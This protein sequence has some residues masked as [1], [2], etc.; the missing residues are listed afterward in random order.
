MKSKN[1]PTCGFPLTAIVRLCPEAHPVAEIIPF[2]A[3]TQRPIAVPGEGAPAVVPIVQFD[4][5]FAA[6][7]GDE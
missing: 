5:P 6:L 3:R 1:C 2:G 7:K 4:G